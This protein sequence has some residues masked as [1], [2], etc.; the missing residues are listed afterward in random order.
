MIEQFYSN[1][2]V[3]ERL[4]SGPLGPYMASVA[5]QLFE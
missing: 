5:T 3:L 4:R 1:P 2:R